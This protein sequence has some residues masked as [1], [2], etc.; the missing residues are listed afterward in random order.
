MRLQ[1]APSSLFRAITNGSLLPPHQEKHPGTCD[2]ALVSLPLWSYLALLAPMHS[3]LQTYC[4]KTLNALILPPSLVSSYM[5]FHPPGTLPSPA[6]EWLLCSFGA[7]L[8]CHILQEA[9][10]AAHLS[11]LAGGVPLLYSNQHSVFL[12]SWHPSHWIVL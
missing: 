10:L 12:P 7:P 3:V 2:L 5:L 4:R 11:R 6:V 8:S 1:R 9:F